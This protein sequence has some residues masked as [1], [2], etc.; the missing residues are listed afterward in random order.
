MVTDAIVTW[1]IASAAI[2]YPTGEVSKPEKSIS[3]GCS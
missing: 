1:V 3:S 2:T